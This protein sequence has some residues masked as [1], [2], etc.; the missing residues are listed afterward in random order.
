MHD[1]PPEEALEHYGVKGMRWGVRNDARPPKLPNRGKITQKGID[2][3]RK[4]H[5]SRMERVAREENVGNVGR[6]AELK[7][8][9]LR[10]PD[11]A[12]AKRMKRGEIAAVA[13]FGMVYPSVS[14]AYATARQVDIVRTR[15]DIQ[16]RNWQQ[17][18]RGK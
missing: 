18:R 13:A 11:R 14:I 17:K 3:A 2:R 8:A 9:A 1:A 10:H 7:A 4:S 6:A 15:K 16:N 5:R 12:N